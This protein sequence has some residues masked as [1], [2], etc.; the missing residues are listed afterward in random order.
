MEISVHTGKVTRKDAGCDSP[1]GSVCLELGRGAEG[2]TRWKP[3]H[4]KGEVP[5]RDLAQ[6]LCCVAVKHTFKT[7]LHSNRSFVY[8]VHTLYLSLY[9]ARSP[10]RRDFQSKTLLSLR[11]LSSPLGRQHLLRG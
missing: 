8:Q 11:R 1:G 2:K 9:K 5:S 3:L 4:H 10:R 6:S 7:R